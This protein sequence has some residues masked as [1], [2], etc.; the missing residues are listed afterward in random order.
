MTPEVAQVARSLGFTPEAL[1]ACVTQQ[2]ADQLLDQIKKAYRRRAAILHP[3]H[4]GDTEEFKLLTVAYSQAEKSLKQLDFQNRGFRVI[5]VSIITDP[6]A[7]A[8]G[9]R[10]FGS[11]WWNRTR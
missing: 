7:A 10:H 11:N 6:V 3:D 4:G 1:R 2:Q 8:G 9:S 5:S